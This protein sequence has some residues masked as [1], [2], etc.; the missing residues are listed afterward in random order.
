MPRARAR[1]GGSDL[2]LGGLE[3]LEVERVADP[4]AVDDRDVVARAHARQHSRLGLGQIQDLLL[5]RAV[6]SLVHGL[7]VE[8][9][10][11]ESTCHGLRS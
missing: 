1:G 8:A 5:E 2:P 4:L 11:G 6:G 3:H 9:V 7:E 10:F